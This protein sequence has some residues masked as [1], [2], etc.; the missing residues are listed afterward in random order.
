MNLDDIGTGE[1]ALHCTTPYLRC[2][3]AQIKGE[4]FYP[5]GTRLNLRR[6]RTALFRNR[7]DGFIRL[8]HNR[9]STEDPGLLGQY[10]CEI[11]DACGVLV[12]LHITLGNNNCNNTMAA[13]YHNA[14]AHACWLKDPPER[15]QTL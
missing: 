6:D 1:D 11:P 12:Y 2:C 8:N 9:A 5:N 7:D 15:E 10:T 4:F 14:R 13:E 3:K